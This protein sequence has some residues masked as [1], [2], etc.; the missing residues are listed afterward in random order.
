MAIDITRVTIRPGDTIVLTFDEPVADDV[1]DAACEKIK[2]SIG[3]DVSVI[4]VHGIKLTVV[5]L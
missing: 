5:G 2:V 4:A 1:A 3:C